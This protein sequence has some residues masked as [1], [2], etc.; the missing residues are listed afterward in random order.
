[1]F[2]LKEFVKKGL[3]NAVGK[4]AEYITSE[5]TAYGPRHGVFGEYAFS[6]SSPWQ[7]MYELN[8]KM[9]SGAV[10]TSPKSKVYILSLRNLSILSLASFNKIP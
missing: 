1:M 5:H 10:L 3:L 2:S 9:I 4:M 7:R 6:H 8:A